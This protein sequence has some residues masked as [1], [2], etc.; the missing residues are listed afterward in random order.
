MDLANWLPSLVMGLLFTTIGILKIY[1][2]VYGIEGGGRKPLKQ[3][4]CGT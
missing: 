3:R 1:G 4:M 2:L